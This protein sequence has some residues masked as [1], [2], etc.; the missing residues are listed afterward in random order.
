MSELSAAEEEVFVTS[1]PG[2]PDLADGCVAG[3]EEK[4]DCGKCVARGE[5][6]EWDTGLTFR[7]SGLER[8]HP[9]MIQSRGRS[10]GVGGGAFKVCI[11]GTCTSVWDMLMIVDRGNQI[12]I[13]SRTF[14]TKPGG[15]YTAGTKLR[16]RFCAGSS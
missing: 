2:L 7:L 8:D 15:C 5:D 12:R 14:R 16:H 13:D 4:P 6:C 11:C 9:S 10:S 3:G 1:T